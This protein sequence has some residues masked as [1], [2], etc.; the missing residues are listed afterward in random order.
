MDPSLLDV[1]H[2]PAEQQL[3][4]VVD[5]VDVDLDRRLEESVDEDRRPGQLRVGLAIHLPHVVGQLF[6]AVHD[7]HLPAPE[8]EGWP[9]HD[10][11]T[12]PGRPRLRPRAPMKPSRR[13]LTETQAPA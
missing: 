6:D 11:K 10:R 3:G 9:D 1:L 12:R 13:R 2:D 5:R 8:D 7:P 4:A